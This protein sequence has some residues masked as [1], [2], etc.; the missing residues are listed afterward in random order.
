[1][2]DYSER[3]KSLRLCGSTR[4]GI[5]CAYCP[6]NG[7]GCHEKLCADAA[8][9]IEELQARLGEAENSVERWKDM[10]LTKYEPKHGEWI[11]CG[12]IGF[13][14]WECSVCGGHGRGDYKRCPWCGAKMEVQ[15]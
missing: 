11:Q 15:E 13:P 14:N 6:Y 4:Y 10:F 2:M 8:A 1:M 7:H 3:V 9:A 12:E 5:R